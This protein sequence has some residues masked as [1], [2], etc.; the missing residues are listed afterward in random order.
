MV[1]YGSYDRLR[2]AAFHATR[3]EAANRWRLLEQAGVQSPTALQSLSAS[4][5]SSLVR[6]GN[7][8]VE[9]SRL[10]KPAPHI[11]WRECLESSGGALWEDGVLR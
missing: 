10:T 2:H 6:L 1:G 4:V 11:D 8:L 9:T 5:G 7:I 3:L